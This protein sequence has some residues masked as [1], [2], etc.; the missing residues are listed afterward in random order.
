MD[1]DNKYWEDLLPRIQ[2][3]YNLNTVSDQDVWE[4]SLVLSAKN[5][6]HVPDFSDYN[7]HIFVGYRDSFNAQQEIGLYLQEN[8][9]PGSSEIETQAFGSLEPSIWFLLLMAVFYKLTGMNIPGFGYDSIPWKELGYVDVW[10][11]NKGEWWRLLCGLTLHA[12]IAHILGN[13]AIGGVFVC[14]LCRKYGSGYGWVFVLGSGILGNYLNT[15]LQD[16]TH[17]SRGFST[18]VFGAVGILAGSRCLEKGLDFDKRQ[19]IPLVAGLGIL[20]LLGSGGENTDL[21]AHILG[22][23]SGLGLGCAVGWCTKN[24]L[25]PTRKGNQ[26]L[27]LLALGSV[28]WAWYLA[29]AHGQ[30]PDAI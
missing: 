2:K 10:A 11:V 1:Q 23:C 24:D 4:W 13:I 28:I 20:S 29:L 12:N 16:Y 27:G 15:L 21:G 18:A 3:H 9:E 25:L 22:F 6:E 7:W 19:M 5:I 17:K 30:L 14:I 26:L 8:T